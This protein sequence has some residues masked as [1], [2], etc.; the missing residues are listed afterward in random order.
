MPASTFAN[1][2][3]IAYRGGSGKSPAA[4][5]DVCLSPPS[6]PAG[7]LPVP[8]PNTGFESDTTEGSRNVKIGGQE[9]LLKDRSYFKKSTGDE[10]ATRAQGMNVVTHQIQGK[11]YF[12][13][14]S[15]NVK[16][17]GEN[18]VRH[19]D[20]TTHNH[21]SDP[22][23]TPPFPDI[24]TL[25]VGGVNCVTLL[26]GL[27]ITVHA[28]KDRDKHCSSTQQSDHIVQNACFENVRGGGGI[29]SCP[30]YNLGN[31]PCMCLDDAT[32]TATEHGK[33]T[34]AQNDWG[35]A[36][37]AGGGSATYAQSR[38][39]NLKASEDAYPGLKGNKEALECLKLIC[40][41]YFKDTLGMDENT[42]V[43]VPRTGKFK[44]PAVDGTTFTK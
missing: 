37:R 15:M 24:S 4:F 10:A 25:Q 11:V 5:P 40:D 32:D 44:P 29:S 39:A 3:A 34:L 19:L 13:A 43:R 30:Q 26:A 21:A 27:K 35:K 31:A 12:R 36:Q 23:G 2:R 22:P 16:A 38:D 6:P 20:L 7:P 8:Y 14:W 42:P 9:V 41:A 1:G 33:K 28:Y 17:E 18:V